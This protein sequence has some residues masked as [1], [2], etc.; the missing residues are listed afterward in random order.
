MHGVQC[1]NS[2]ATAESGISCTPNSC[3]IVCELLHAPYLTAPVM[4]SSLAGVCTVS[5]HCP[6]TIKSLSY[7]DVA[8]FVETG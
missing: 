6:F 1:Q 4:A 5:G 2:W 8:S 3:A 7:R